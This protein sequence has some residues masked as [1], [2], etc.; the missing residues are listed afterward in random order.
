M[1]LTFDYDT[2]GITLRA[3]QKTGLARFF[4]R[5]AISDLRKLPAAERDLILAIADLRALSDDESLHDLA[6]R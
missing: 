6:W 3:T 5:P 1:E 4:S 2:A